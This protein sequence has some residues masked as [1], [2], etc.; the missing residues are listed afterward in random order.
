M[1]KHFNDDDDDDDDENNISKEKMS[2]SQ[3][4]LS[5]TLARL[6]SFW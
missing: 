1:R 4:F 3:Q 5:V 2:T 6:T